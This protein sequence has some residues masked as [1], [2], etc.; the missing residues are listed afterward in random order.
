VV[1]VTTAEGYDLLTGD[2]VHAS[3]NGDRPIAVAPD[4][5]WLVVERGRRIVLVPA[6]AEQQPDT[7]PVDLGPLNRAVHFAQT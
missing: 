1:A 2:G 4:G 6:D 3:E 7:D 5:Q